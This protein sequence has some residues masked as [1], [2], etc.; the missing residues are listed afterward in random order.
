MLIASENDPH[1][2]LE[3]AKGL[4]SDWGSRLVNIGPQGHINVASGHGPRPEG[5]LLFREFQVSVA[6]GHLGGALSRSG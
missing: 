6:A 1:R 5:E 4:A 3:R 2:S